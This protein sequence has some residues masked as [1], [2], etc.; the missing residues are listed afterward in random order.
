MYAA[1]LPCNFGGTIRLTSMAVTLRVKITLILVSAIS[2]AFLGT[3]QVPIHV[4]HSVI[5]NKLIA[6]KKL[7]GN[8]QSTLSI[9]I[10]RQCLWEC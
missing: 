7:P 5:I 2:V 9:V 4:G 1:D 3:L 8:S 10:R 6:G